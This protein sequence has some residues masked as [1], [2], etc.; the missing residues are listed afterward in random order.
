MG[1]VLQ[2]A[3]DAKAGIDGKK[4]QYGVDENK[5][6]FMKLKG[7]IAETMAAPILGPCICLVFYRFVA[8]F[9]LVFFLSTISAAVPTFYEKK[10]FAS[11]EFQTVSTLTP[12]VTFR[13]HHRHLSHRQHRHHRHLHSRRRLTRSPEPRT[14]DPIARIPRPCLLHLRRGLIVP[15]LLCRWS[16]CQTST[17]AC[18][19]LLWPSSC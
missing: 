11:V 16:R 7:V 15:S 4:A 9:A 13:H 5:S 17:C 2:K 18:P 1:N 14:E 8:L 6:E 3:A 10:S 12:A 19:L